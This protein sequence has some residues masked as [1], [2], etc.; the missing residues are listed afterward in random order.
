MPAPS[1]IATGWWYDALH[2]PLGTYLQTPAKDQLLALL[3]KTR[4]QLDDPAL[5][6][7]T[8]R[9]SPRDPAGE[10]WL[11]RLDPDPEAASA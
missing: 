3:Y 1:A 6:R 8:I 2:S 10:L 4:K 5:S 7:I 11:V 9:S